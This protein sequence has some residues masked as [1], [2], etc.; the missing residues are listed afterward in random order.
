MIEIGLGSVASWEC[1]QQGHMNVQFY[2]GRASDSLPALLQALGLGPRQCRALDV[3][4]MPLDQHIRFLRELRPSE[5][6]TI[7]GGVLGVAEDRLRLYQEMRNTLSGAVAASFVTEAVLVDAERRQGRVP[8][9][10]ALRAAAGALAVTLPDDAKPRGLALAPPRPRP[11]WSE[12]D[13]LGLALTQQAALSPAECD[14]RG[15]MVTRAA[16]GR[17]ADSMPNLIAK[18]LGYDR[19]AGKSGNAALEYRLVYHATPRQGDVLALRAGVKAIGGKSVTWA[20]WLFDRETGDAA[21]TAEAVT[22]TFDIAQRKATEVT[23]A[24]REALD[25]LRVPGLSA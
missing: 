22:V 19:S 5:P 9:P 4:L 17:V 14:G 21:V 25:R 18:A 6:F 13:R 23:P 11:S 20:H 3:V 7:V 24:M 16:M 8:L 10:E 2:L 12:A 1:D 15:F